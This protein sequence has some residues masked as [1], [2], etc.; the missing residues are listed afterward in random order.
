MKTKINDVEIEGTPDEVLYVVQN[1][2]TPKTFMVAKQETK[3]ETPMRVIYPPERVKERRALNKPKTVRYP[4]K[5]NWSKTAEKVAKYLKAH[6]N[7]AYTNEDIR[8]SFGLS[9][10]TMTYNI[11]PVL[12]KKRG[13][14]IYRDGHNHKMFKAGK[15]SELKKKH[16]PSKYATF[17]GK[18]VKKLCGEGL[19]HKTAFKQ[20]VT[21]WNNT[22]AKAEA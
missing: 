6:P 15:K 18:T 1:L 7:T 2:T 10:P 8:K 13:I 14:I 19:N 22:K 5:N 4:Y 17:L 20:A 16:A 12:A 21:T 9:H 3:P 11:S